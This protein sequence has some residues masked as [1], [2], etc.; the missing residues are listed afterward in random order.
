MIMISC[1]SSLDISA[2]HTIHRSINR[3]AITTPA[4]VPTVEP[5]APHFAT[6]PS[7]PSAKYLMNI[8]A[9][10]RLTAALKN[11]LKDL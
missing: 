4:V 9:A 8:H 6:L 5:A 3:S 11:L 1:Y 10:I 7:L 2:I